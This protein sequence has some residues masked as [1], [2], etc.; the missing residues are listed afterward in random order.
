MSR[1]LKPKEINFL[2]PYRQKQ[3]QSAGKGGGRAKW[4]IPPVLLAGLFAVVFGV[5]EW[6]GFALRRQIRAIDSYLNDAAVQAQYDEAQALSRELSRYAEAYGDMRDIRAAIASYPTVG[7]AALNRVLGCRQEDMTYSSLTYDRQTA[8]LSIEGR[9]ASY[10]DCPPLIDRLRATGLF[11][12]VTY[13]G[14]NTQDGRFAFHA[15][16]RLKGGAADE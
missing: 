16:C 1:A 12:E 15:Y 3:A 5:Y 2:L 14:Y 7:S 6:G 8:M 13:N 10:A 11:D 9:A 4:V